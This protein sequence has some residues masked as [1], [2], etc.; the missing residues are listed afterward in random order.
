MRAAAGKLGVK[1]IV[2]DAGHVFWIWATV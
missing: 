1:I 2:V